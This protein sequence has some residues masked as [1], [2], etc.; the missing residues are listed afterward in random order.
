MAVLKFGE[1]LFHHGIAPISYSWNCTEGRV[2]AL[3]IPTKKELANNLIMTSRYIRDNQKNNDKTEFFTSFNSSSIYA[4][5][6][7]EGETLVSVLLAIEYPE[8]YRS[9]QNW[10]KSSVTVKVTDRLTISVPQ[11]STYQEKETH[12][13]LVPPHTQTKIETNKKSRLKLGYSQ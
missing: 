11:Y 8:K 1:E 7:H 12:M 9:E 2:L 6:E 3:D 13:Y 5:G 10:Y 4:T